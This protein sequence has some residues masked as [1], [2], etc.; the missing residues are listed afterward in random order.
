MSGL[1]YERPLTH[2]LIVSILEALGVEVEKVSIDALLNNSIYTAT[3]VLKRE[4]KGKTEKISIDSRPSD[5]IAIAI[6]TGAP[7]FVAEHL[8]KYARSME[9]IGI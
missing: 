9:E 5:G 2:D 3:I 4:I 1:R 7:I 6:R 8:E